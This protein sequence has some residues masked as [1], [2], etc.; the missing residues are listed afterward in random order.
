M[1]TLTMLAENIIVI[2]QPFVL[3]I[4]Q[5]E[6]MTKWLINWLYWLIVAALILS[7]YMIESSALKEAHQKVSG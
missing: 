1:E 6:I 7:D 5:L 2:D 3:M 4:D